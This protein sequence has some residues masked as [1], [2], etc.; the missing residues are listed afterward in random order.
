MKLIPNAGKVAKGASSMWLIY[1]AGA[2]ELGEK[3]MPQLADY[4]PWYVKVG[5]LAAAGVSRLIRQEK[6]HV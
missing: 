1:G 5:V 3:L 6:L 4:L 2:L